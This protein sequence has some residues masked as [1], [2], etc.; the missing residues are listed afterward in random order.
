M[1]LGAVHAADLKH[2]AK[3]AREVLLVELRG[4]GEVS[5]V[6]E[7]VQLEQ[8]GAALRA[9]DYDFGRVDMGKALRLH[10]LR[11][12]VRDG[13]LHA[14]HRLLD[15]VAQRNR[16]QRQVNVER[17]AHI[18]F[19]QR[20]RQLVVRTAEHADRT[21]HNL[22]AVL[23]ARLLMHLA[24]DLE[25]HR[26]LDLAALDAADLVPLEGALDQAALNAHDDKGKIRHIAHAVHRA[27]EGDL[28]A[29]R[30][31]YALDGID[32]L[33]RFVNHFHTL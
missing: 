28:A 27:A 7:V 9:R 18:L 22:D 13:A 20:H 23:G 21:E 16:T 3:C 8:V 33:R 25:H 14:E 29:D 11:K 5:R 17:Q 26:V 19:A 2:A 24:G 15:R 10:I 12:A 4:L 6:A 1:A 31:A 32:V 30:I